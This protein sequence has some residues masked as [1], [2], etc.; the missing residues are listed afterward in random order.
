MLSRECWRSGLLRDV[1]HRGKFGFA[2][3]QL[4]VVEDER[5]LRAP[6]VGR[7]AGNARLPDPLQR[8]SSEDDLQGVCYALQPRP[9]TLGAGARN[10]GATPGRGS[11]QPAS[12]ST[13]V[14]VQHRIDSRPR[15]VTSRISAGE[16]GCVTR[17]VVFADHTGSESQEGHG[18]HPLRRAG[19]TG[20]LTMPCKNLSRS[21]VTSLSQRIG[22]WLQTTD[23]QDLPPRKAGSP[24]LRDLMYTRNR[25][26]TE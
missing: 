15:R 2:S 25:Y 14:W 24:P 20:S 23:K 11:S 10:P 17:D 18:G 21:N 19:C 12:T 4:R 13:P 8:T 26:V 9:P 16:G 6:K 22:S 1:S 5:L 3:R 7:F